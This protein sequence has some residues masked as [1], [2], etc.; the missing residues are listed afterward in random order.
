MSIS[1]TKLWTAG[2]V[3]VSLALVLATWFLV[4]SPQRAV[5]ADLATDRAAAEA[6]NASI[7]LKTEQLQAQFTTLP[8]RR[9]E[10]AEI[11]SEFPSEVEVPALL[12]SLEQYA[13]SAG[14]T[15]VSITPGALEAYTPGVDPAA[16]T[17]PA[18]SGTAISA[19]PVT[20]AVSGSF[21]QTELFV[22]QVQ[23]DMKRYLLLENASLAAEDSAAG[24]TSAVTTTLIG[25]IFVLPATGA[26][27][28]APAATAT[29]PA[30][31]PPSATTTETT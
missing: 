9:A 21:A 6:S 11:R 25:R 30:L 13:T 2:A 16:A 28:E 23:A 15:L 7:R 10:L 19:L 31:T 14:V 8:E 18:S 22:K 17:A 3:L 29:T 4:I 24:T 12:R 27:T 1:K 20:V 26:V 5:A